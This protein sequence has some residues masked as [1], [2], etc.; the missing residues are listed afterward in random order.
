MQRNRLPGA[1]RWR[2]T[3]AALWLALLTG[4]PGL[5]QP[6]TPGEG[7][8]GGTEAP[9]AGAPAPGPSE[10]PL[11]QGVAPGNPR[12]FHGNF[13]GQ[14]DAGPGAAP[15]DSLDAAC[16]R[17]DLCYGR[18]GASACSCDRELEAEAAALANAPSLSPDVRSKARTV[19]EVV[20][21]LAC[22]RED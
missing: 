2:S 21:R 17:H 20:R 14:G 5:A 16:R 4:A 18:R 19:F 7:P 22:W 3:L 13:C 1:R 15:V 11:A 12:L 8:R 10:D 6:V 9:E